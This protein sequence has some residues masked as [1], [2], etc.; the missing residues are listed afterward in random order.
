M[1]HFVLHHST[2]GKV[3]YIPTGFILSIIKQGYFSSKVRW[4]ISQ[5]MIHM[6]SFWN[7]HIGSSFCLSLLNKCC[8]VYYV[9]TFIIMSTSLLY[10]PLHCCHHKDII[11]HQMSWKM[12]ISSKITKESYSNVIS[13]F[14]LSYP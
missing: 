11:K 5:T 7:W 12:H 10:P 8:L 4:R 9:T 2:T 1:W 13:S 14:K 3:K 6:P